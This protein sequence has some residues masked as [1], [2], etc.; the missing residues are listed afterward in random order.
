VGHDK[1]PEIDSIIRS[2]MDDVMNIFLSKKKGSKLLSVSNCA[3]E[4]RDL[5]IFSIDDITWQH[6]Q[7]LFF[8]RNVAKSGD[9]TS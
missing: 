8:A 7:R 9:F 1:W 6:R 4:A 3:E 2:F 5:T